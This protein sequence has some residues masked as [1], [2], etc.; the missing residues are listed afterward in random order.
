MLKPTG[1][2]QSLWVCKLL[3]AEICCNQ[4]NSISRRCNKFEG[5]PI[6]SNCWKALQRTNYKPWL[7]LA[8]L[9]HTKGNWKLVQMRVHLEDLA[10]I[11]SSSWWYEF[12]GHTI[13]HELRKTHITNYYTNVIPIK[14]WIVLAQITANLEFTLQIGWLFLYSRWSLKQM[15][16][17]TT[18]HCMAYVLD[19]SF[20]PFLFLRYIH[21]F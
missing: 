18:S 20:S 10:V 8:L 1:G 4:W 6:L 5:G 13:T 17:E 12:F 2:S 15:R 14:V 11:L 9:M 3:C 7:V 21:L 19:L 16:E